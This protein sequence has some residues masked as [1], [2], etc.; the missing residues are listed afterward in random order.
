VAGVAAGLQVPSQ[1]AEAER[2]N[3][4]LHWPVAAAIDREPGLEDQPMR[5]FC[6]LWGCPCVAGPAWDGDGQ[7]PLTSAFGPRSLR[8]G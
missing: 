4:F 7:M 2:T 5:R 8:L 1:V 3:A 6:W